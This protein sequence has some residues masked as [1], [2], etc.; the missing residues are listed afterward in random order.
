MRRNNEIARA[1][2]VEARTDL[3]SGRGLS[4]L[5]EYARTVTH[6]QQSVE[7]ALKAMLATQGL[8]SA[9]HDVSEPFRTTFPEL[10]E[11]DRI[12]DIASR[13]ESIGARSRYPLFGRTD[14]PIWIPSEQYRQPDAQQALDEAT[15]VFNTLTQYL[16]DQHNV[17]L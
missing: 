11:V 9:T 14:L 8:F 4:Q 16:A 5:G 12:A 6:C 7:K 3:R 10:S 15:F 2:L 1:F 17:H 13:L